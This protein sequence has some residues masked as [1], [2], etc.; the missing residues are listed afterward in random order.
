MT[1]MNDGEKQIRKIDCEV[2]CQS[3]E[4]GYPAENVLSADTASCWKATPYYQWLLIDLKGLYKVDR[5]K[6]VFGHNGEYYRYHIEYST[7]RLNWKLLLEKSNEE[8]ETSEGRTYSVNDDAKYIRITV[9]Y[10]SVSSC[11]EIDSVEVFGCEAE[12]EKLEFDITKRRERA[13]MLTKM[14][15]FNA[16]PTEELE[17]GWKDSALAADKAGSWL[18]IEK[19]DFGNGKF[20]QLRFFMGTPFKSKTHHLTIEFRLDAP[21]GELINRI[22]PTKQWVCWVE[23]A[24]AFFKADKNPITGVHDIYIVLTGVE[25][26]QRLQILWLWLTKKHDMPLEPLDYRE[27]LDGTNESD[28]YRTFFGNMHCHTS[29][30]DGAETPEFA[31][32]YAREVAG[33]DFLGITEHSNCLDEMFDHD[34]SRKFRDIIKKA[35]EMTEKDKFI[36]LYGTETTF[37]NQF[38]HMNV[39]C[40]DF[41]INAYEFK[42]DDKL[43]YYRTLKEFPEVINQW[44]HPWSSGDRHLDLFKPYDPELDK[45]MYTIELNDVEME[46]K[47]VLKYYINA[48]DEG[49]HVAPVGNQDNHEVNWGTQNGIRTGVIVK[50]LTAGHIYDAM[51]NLRTYF[52]GAPGIR[53]I[54]TLNGKMQ[55]QILK[56]GSPLVMKLKGSLDGD[57]NFV[58]VDVYGEHGKIVATKGLSGN[59]VDLTMPL[60]EGERYYFLKVVREDNRYAIT[61]PVWVE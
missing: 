18:Q 51:R 48:L 23:I 53:V 4:E 58:R 9:S 54:Y 19:V 41:F 50:R 32:R 38:G 6:V 56:K 17:P 3:S 7:D 52:T 33:L 39:Y 10:C 2:F 26:P 12:P 28:E 25:E 57:H 22:H 16:E 49:W 11:V 43:E 47:D 45:V 46:E 14:S 59:R 13:V 20:D 35:D 1:I 55:G 5:L 37:Y 21:D 34:K 42:Y 8:A 31:Y 24:V 15:G 44:N 29:F 40:A 61:A 36:A 27:D 30:S 60:E